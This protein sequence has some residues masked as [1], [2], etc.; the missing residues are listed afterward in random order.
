MK[1][2]FTVFFV[3]FLS[4][5]CSQEQ[6]L[7]DVKIVYGA[8]NRTFHRTI[9]IEKKSFSVVFKRDT[10][11]VL[12]ALTEEQWQEIGNLYAKIDLKTYNDLEGATMEYAYDGKPHAN[13]SIE[14][15]GKTYATKG[16]DHTIPPVQIKEF[17]DYINKLVNDSI[18]INPVLGS[19]VVEEL[20]SND[21]SKKEYFISFD[22]DK[23]SGYMGCNFYSGTYKIQNNSISLSSLMATKKYC[24]NEMENETLWLNISST[25]SFFKIENKTILLYDNENKLLLK[26]TK[27]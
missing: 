15:K 2:L 17:V 20:A 21:V 12:I 16:F 10:K 3:I 27:K 13:M 18:P 24:A 11:P 6:D 8:N 22:E 14:V 5:G 9:F 1:S 19:Y 26:A 7:S 23:V 4:K 25:V